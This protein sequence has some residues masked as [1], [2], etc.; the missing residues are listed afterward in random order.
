VGPTVTFR[1]DSSTY[2][3]KIVGFVASTTWGEVQVMALDFAGQV[4][5]FLHGSET[6]TLAVGVSIHE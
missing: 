5:T 2:T 4:A 1:V 6:V 3:S